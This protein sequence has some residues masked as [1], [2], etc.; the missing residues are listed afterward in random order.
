MCG[1]DPDRVKKWTEL[2]GS[3]LVKKTWVSGD[4]IYCER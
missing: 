2:N 4:L 1:S 3:G